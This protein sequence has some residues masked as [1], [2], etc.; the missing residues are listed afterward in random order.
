MSRVSRNSCLFEKKPVNNSYTELQERITDNSISDAR[1]QTVGQI[2]RREYGPKFGHDRFPPCQFKFFYASQY[3]HLTLI[4]RVPTTALHA[5]QIQNQAAHT[6]GKHK[7]LCRTHCKSQTTTSQM[8]LA[9]PTMGSPWHPAYQRHVP[10]PQ[11]VPCIFNEQ[12]PTLICKD[13]TFYR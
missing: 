5:P 6:Q 1:S 7:T 10:R 11:S 3:C 13:Q 4:D 12:L 9:L 8:C 2:K